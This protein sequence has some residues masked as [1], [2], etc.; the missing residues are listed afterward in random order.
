MTTLLLFE[1]LT[2]LEGFE[3]RLLFEKIILVS[4][5]KTETSRGY[6]IEQQKTSVIKQGIVQLKRLH[7][8]IL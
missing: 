8:T 3:Q 4:F 5:I 6:T 7:L 1:H 2:K